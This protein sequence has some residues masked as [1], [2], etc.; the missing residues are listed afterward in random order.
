MNWY[1][2][3]HCHCSTLMTY[4]EGN[5]PG[6]TAPSSCGQAELHRACDSQVAEQR[7]SVPH[8]LA[9]IVGWVHIVGGGVSIVCWLLCVV[10]PFTLCAQSLLA[11]GNDGGGGGR[12]PE[13]AA[14]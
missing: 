3:S 5:T 11:A 12:T 8:L 10:Q 1:S 13:V 6:A 4:L 9:Y 14:I 7:L 2:S